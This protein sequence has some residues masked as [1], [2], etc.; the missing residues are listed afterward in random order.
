MADGLNF[1]VEPYDWKQLPE[2]VFTD[3]GG[4]KEAKKLRKL[5][6]GKESKPKKSKEVVVAASVVADSQEDSQFDESTQDEQLG[7]EEAEGDAP[8][9]AITAPGA[10]RESPDLK[11]RGRQEA[12]LEADHDLQAVSKAG[13]FARIDIPSFF[14]TRRL[15]V[16]APPLIQHI[17]SV[18][19]NLIGTS[20]K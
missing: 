8:P 10:L 2:E 12:G 1:S 4:R 16:N 13:A 9:L 6:L 15:G 17:S 18:S 19:W 7:G 5:L 3:F 20:T 11:K 14:H